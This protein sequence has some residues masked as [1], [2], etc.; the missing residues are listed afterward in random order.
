MTTASGGGGGAGGRS[1]D[2]NPP[3]GTGLLCCAGKCVNAANDILNCGSCGNTCA[4][5]H[6]F[7]DQG[8]CEDAPCKGAACTVNAF[9][10]GTNCCG[11][12]QLC[13]VVPVGPVGPPQCTDPVDGTCPPG[14][15]GGICAHPDTPVATP[16][17]ERAINSL[18]VGDLVYSVDRGAITAVPIVS[19]IQRPVSDHVVVRAQLDTGAVLSISPLHPTADGRSFA[20]LKPGDDLMGATVLRVERVAYDAPFTHDILPRSET[21]SYFAGGALIGSSLA[22]SR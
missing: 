9:C 6:P 20:E 2:C 10:C 14:N 15:P 7:C 8:T 11:L 21:G 12:N 18:R 22:P 16:L 5:Q 3:C 4:Q 19:V 17:G 13:C 1:G